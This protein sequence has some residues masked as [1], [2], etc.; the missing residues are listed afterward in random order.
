MRAGPVLALAATLV[1]AASFA[2]AAPRGTAPARSNAPSLF[3]GYS[4]AE[5]GDASLHGLG[6][7]GSYP[8]GDALHLV[9]DLSGHGGSF[10]GADLGQIGLMA[11]ARWTRS[12]GRFRPFAEGL[13]GGV[14]TSTSVVGGDVSISDADTDWGLALGGGLD[15]GLNKRWALRALVHLRLLHGDGTWDTDPRLAIGAV[16]RLGR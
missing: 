5:A 12:Y 16:F 11:G 9:V 13:V 6:L 3:A 4:Y 8:L 10:A 2:S 7:S 15:Y 14:R 1:V